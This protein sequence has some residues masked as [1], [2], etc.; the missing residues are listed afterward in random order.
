MTHMNS[1]HGMGS[2]IYNDFIIDKIVQS[3]KNTYLFIA[4]P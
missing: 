3:E 4:V 2:F 1:S